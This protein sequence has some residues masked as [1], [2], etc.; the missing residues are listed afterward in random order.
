MYACARADAR[1]VPITLDRRHDHHHS[2]SRSHRRP[3]Y[4]ALA[5][6]RV[7]APRVGVQRAVLDAVR[8][9]RAIKAVRSIRATLTV[10]FPRA[11][12][13][14][15][16]NRAIWAKQ[17]DSHVVRSPDTR[18]G[19]WRGVIKTVLNILTVF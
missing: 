2:E 1:L 10:Y 4:V 9:I 19:R 3:L 18:Y 12:W 7:S 17:S 8:S 11:I 13:A 16:S 14:L 6:L 15:R 5:H